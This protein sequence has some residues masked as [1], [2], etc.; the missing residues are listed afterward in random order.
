MIKVDCPECHGTGYGEYEYC[1][2]KHGYRCGTCRPLEHCP[3]CKA[4]WY[5][6]NNHHPG[7]SKMGTLS[8]RETLQLVDSKE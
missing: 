4:I 8:P 3:E 5:H 7:C 2:K 1:G 6:P